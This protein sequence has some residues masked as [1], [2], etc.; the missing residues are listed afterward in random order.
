LKTKIIKSTQEKYS[1]YLENQS[2]FFNDL[3][4]ND[5]ESYNDL[6]WDK[7]RKF[8]VDQILK[9]ISPVAKILDV[10][11]GCGFHDLLMAENKEVEEVFGID[12]S[13]KSIETANRIYSHNKVKRKVGD[14]FSIEPGNYD[15][16]VSFQVIE[17]VTDSLAFLKAC[18]RQVRPGGWVVVA[19]PNRERIHNRFR[20]LLW[21]DPILEDPQ[22]FLE[23]T[24]PEL[25]RI[26]KMA[27]LNTESIIGYGL[28]LNI[29]KLGYPIIP[30]GMWRIGFSIPSYADRFCLILRDTRCSI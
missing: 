23:Y 16:V 24:A 14:I 8:E 6:H 12:Y 30:K 22:H 9:T 7:V 10:G 3:I 26:G 17:H 5:W 21:L 11:C 18:A 28:T 2:I 15:L 29:P 19:T 27:G 25:T 20:R 1:V 4:T 13:E